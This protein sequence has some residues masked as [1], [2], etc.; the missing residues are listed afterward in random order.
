MDEDTSAFCFLL[1]AY[2]ALSH[3][4]WRKGLV[5]KFPEHD[6]TVLALPVRFFSWRLRSNSLTWAFSE[7]KVL[8]AGYD[9]LVCTSMIDLSSLK[10]MVPELTK[11]PTLCYFHENQFAYPASE[12]Q[13]ASVEPLILNIYT[14]LAADQVLFNSVCNRQTFIEGAQ[15]Y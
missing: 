14:A 3:Q 4:Y 2:D 1:S 15:N 5:D 6:W 8:T 10:G 11:I 7:R 13:S 9:L 12:Q